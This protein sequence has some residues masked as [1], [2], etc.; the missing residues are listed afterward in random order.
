MIKEKQQNLPPVN[1]AMEEVKALQREDQAKESLNLKV[2]RKNSAEPSKLPVSVFRQLSR[3]DATFKVNQPVLAKVPI[4]SLSKKFE[5]K[6][7]NEIKAK[8]EKAL[9]PPYT[10][11]TFPID[12]KINEIRNLKASDGKIVVESAKQP[13]AT[14]QLSRE[15]TSNKVNLPIKTP[16]SYLSQKFEENIGNEIKAKQ[17]QV[18]PP[19][20]REKKEIKTLQLDDQLNESRNLKVTDGLSY[21]QTSKLPVAVR[22]NSRDGRLSIQLPL[23][24]SISRDNEQRLP[25][26]SSL[27]DKISSRNPPLTPMPSLENTEQNRK[28]SIA[29]MRESFFSNT[30]SLV[31]SSFPSVNVTDPANLPPIR[32]EAKFEPK[33]N[34]QERTTIMDVSPALVAQTQSNPVPWR[35]NVARTLSQEQ[36]VHRARAPQPFEPQHMLQENPLYVRHAPYRN[37]VRPLYSNIVVSEFTSQH[38]QQTTTTTSPKVSTAK[39]VLQP[40]GSRL[41]PNEP[42]STSMISSIPNGES[43]AKEQMSSSMIIPPSNF[44]PSKGISDY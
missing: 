20:N 2:I 11:K 13:V 5:E 25:K 28:S 10:E 42:M 1:V 32:I 29:A 19:L 15:D 36:F 6:V 27:D 3:E 18:L 22:Q 37:A 40:S 43:K 34:E 35:R 41:K 39:L 30:S 38:T 9:P 17:D 33:G 21:G 7:G 24:R 23:I 12:D 31:P 16:V 44:D 26:Q 4:S 14:R 8:Q